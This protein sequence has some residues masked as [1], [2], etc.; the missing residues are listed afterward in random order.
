METLNAFDEHP[1]ITMA[2]I[3]HTQWQGASPK[4]PHQLVFSKA[5]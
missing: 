3:L 1:D 2:S 4:H 5:F